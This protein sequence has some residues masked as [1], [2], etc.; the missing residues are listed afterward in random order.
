MQGVDSKWDKMVTLK[1]MFTLEELAADPAAMLDIKEDIREECSK[2]GEVTNVVLYDKEKDG[3]VSVRF[4]TPQ[5]A[6]ACIKVGYSE[7]INHID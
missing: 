5:A 2:L 3:V 4:S 6:R 1:H 7:M